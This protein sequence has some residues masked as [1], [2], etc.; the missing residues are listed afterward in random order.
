M[1]SPAFGIPVVQ[2]FLAAGYDVVGVVCQPDKPVGRGLRP[3]PAAVKVAAGAAGIPVL[4]PDNLSEPAVAARSGA[5]RADL[6][7]VAAYGKYIPA[8]IVALA[9]ARLPQPAPV[10]VAPLA[11]RLP[12]GGRHPGRRRRDR[13]HHP[14]CDG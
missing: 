13:R 11:G 8:P 10:P 1:S 5:L 14:L 6:I 3:T 2:T 12:D 4:Q 9:A 7:L